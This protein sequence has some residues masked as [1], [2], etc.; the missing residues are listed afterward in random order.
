M[1]MISS[2][3]R[4]NKFGLSF[5][6]CPFAERAFLRDHPASS[7]E[8]P[9]KIVGIN[10]RQLQNPAERAYLQLVV[11]RDDCPNLIAGRRL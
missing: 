11:Q 2:P 3:T 1:T 7:S 9:G 6:Q 5:L 10:L 4:S 8:I